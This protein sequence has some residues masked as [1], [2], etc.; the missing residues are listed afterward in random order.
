[1]Q[2]RELMYPPSVAKTEYIS[3]A[4]M[5]ERYSIGNIAGAAKHEAR[6]V[7]SHPGSS[8]RPASRQ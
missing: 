4:A 7:C 1:M 8:H 3:E 6:K 5:M 2:R